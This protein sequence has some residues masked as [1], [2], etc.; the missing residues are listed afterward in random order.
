MIP[1]F[2]RAC[3]LAL[4]CTLGLTAQPLPRAAAALAPIIEDFV[5]AHD[6][7]GVS[8]ALVEL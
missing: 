8:I 4:A 3:L 5:A 6:R 1:S 7:A 2:R